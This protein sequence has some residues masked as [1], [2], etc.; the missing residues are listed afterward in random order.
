MLH[1]MVEKQQ[2]LTG[3]NGKAL[4]RSCYRSLQHLNSKNIKG[5]VL[6]TLAFAHVGVSDDL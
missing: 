2:T 4:Y 6:M 3:K 1:N 5:G